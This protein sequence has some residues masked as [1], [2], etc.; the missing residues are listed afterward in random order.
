[1]KP[2]VH[3]VIDENTFVPEVGGHA[4]VHPVG[5]ISSLVSNTCSV[6]TSQIVRKGTEG[7][8][9]TRNTIYKPQNDA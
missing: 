8:F 9:E 4:I 3:Y 6:I 7:E 5:H 1:M 2:V